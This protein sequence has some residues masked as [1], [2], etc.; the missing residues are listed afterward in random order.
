MLFSACFIVSGW[1]SY[2]EPVLCRCSERSGCGDGCACLRFGVTFEN[3]QVILWAWQKDKGE[4]MS[5]NDAVY[6]CVIESIVGPD[7][8]R[9]W[10][11][12][13]VVAMGW[14]SIQEMG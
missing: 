6:A 11:T 10:Y 4:G 2:Y 12:V 14:C 3:R 5:I 7:G 13:D 8:R 9:R 1:A